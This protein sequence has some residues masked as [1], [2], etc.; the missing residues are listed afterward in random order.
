MLIPDF[1]EICFGEQYVLSFGLLIWIV[2][3][4]YTSNSRQTL[5]TYRE[6]T[7]IFKKTKYITLVTAIL[8]VGLSILFGYFFGLSGIIAATVVSRM[9]YAW[10][11]EPLIIFKD[12]FKSS[13]KLYFIIYI[14]RLIL[15]SII[16]TVTYIIANV[17]PNINLYVD[18]L[19][20]MIICVIAPIIILYIIYRKSEAFAYL[21]AN[22][23]KRRK[24]NNN[25]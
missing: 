5:W 18:F 12:Y 19:L 2:F 6:T 1:V 3:N 20:K 17:I 14:K 4:F 8:N 13:P 24:G 16:C 10:W 7:G 9:I 15:V 25:G 22:L 11:K 21:K 23:L